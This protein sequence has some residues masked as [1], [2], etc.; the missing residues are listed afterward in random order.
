MHDEVTGR[1]RCSE[2]GTI[3]GR[4]AMY[5][6]DVPVGGDEAPAEFCQQ[7]F[8]ATRVGV[9]SDGTDKEHQRQRGDATRRNPMA[10]LWRHV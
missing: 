10:C 4:A 8:L 3:A 1:L 2:I 7:S 6:H 5:L 9:R